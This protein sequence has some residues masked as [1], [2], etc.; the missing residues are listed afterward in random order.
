[1][2]L[3]VVEASETG[4]SILVNCLQALVG[5]DNC[6]S[7]SLVRLENTGNRFEMLRYQDARLALFPEA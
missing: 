4:K 2:I 6:A 3:E 5:K 7:G 1:M